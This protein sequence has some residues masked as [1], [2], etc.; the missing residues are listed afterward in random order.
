MQNPDGCLIVEK[1][2]NSGD[3]WA[4]RELWRTDSRRLWRLWRCKECYKIFMIKQLRTVWRRDR[5]SKLQWK[6][7]VERRLPVTL[8]SA[9]P[10]GICKLVPNRLPGCWPSVGQSAS[11]L[12]TASVPDNLFH[13]ANQHLMWSNRGRATRDWEDGAKKLHG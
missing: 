13:Y 5:L 10:V 8:M 1:W 7:C 3:L 12:E 2:R 6:L 11:H 9:K 4:S